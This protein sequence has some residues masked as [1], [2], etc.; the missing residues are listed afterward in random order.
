MKNSQSATIITI[1]ILLLCAK[2]KGQEACIDSSYT[3]SY[4][5]PGYTH[6][7]LDHV[8]TAGD[9]TLMAGNLANRLS[10][11]G[12]LKKMNRAG[13]VLW[14]RSIH[15]AHHTT[16]LTR[17]I[18]M[19]NG[20]ISVL[21]NATDTLLNI[22]KVLL[23]KWTSNGTLLW[24]NFYSLNHE[25]TALDENGR[26][27]YS[28]YLAEG[29]A[30]DLL[31]TFR[32]ATSDLIT[33]QTAIHAVHCR[34]DAS[35]QLKWSKAFSP[36][37]S[38]STDPAG[39]FYNGEDVVAL[40]NVSGVCSGT[41]GTDGNVFYAMKLH[42]ETG[43]QLQAAAYC[44]QPIASNAWEGGTNPEK[45]Y[46]NAIQ[47]QQQQYGLFGKFHPFDQNTYYYSLVLDNELQPLRS[48]L[49]TTPRSLSFGNSKIQLTRSGDIH[50]YALNSSQQ[51]I[52]WSTLGADYSIKRERK[53]PLPRGT[54][55]IN[56]SL[57]FA[58]KGS[59]LNFTGNY[60]TGGQIVNVLTQLQ[61]NDPSLNACLG[62]DTAFVKKQSFPVIAIHWEWESGIDNKVVATPVTAI[63]SRPDEQQE[64][65]CR[66]ISRCE[67]L[68][69]HG[70]DTVC[71]L[72]QEVEFTGLTN[73]GCRKKITWVIDPSVVSAISQPD[74][75]TLRVRFKNDGFGPQTV[76]VIA[77]A[78][79]CSIAKDTLLVTLLPISQ[80]LPA[81]T[82][83][84]GSDSMKLTPGHWF[85]SYVWQDGSTDS[86]LLATK[87]G[88]YYV[89]VQ[90]H[91][92]YVLTDTIRIYGKQLDVGAESIICK[93]DTVSLNTNGGFRDYKWYANGLALQT[94]DSVIQAWPQTNTLFH[95]EAQTHG[96]CVE[97][98]S[99]QVTVLQ[100]K[101][102][103]LGR[104]TTLCEGDSLVLDAGPHFNSYIWGNGDSVQRIV[105]KR[106]GN[107]YVSAL[108]DNGCVSADTMQIRKVYPK[109][110]VHLPQR[111]VL[112]R[113]QNN[114][115]DAGSGFQSY[116]W[117]DGSTR[118]RLTVDVPGTY[119]VRVV[120]RNGCHNTAA[121]LITTIAD[122]PLINGLLDTAMC[123]G[124]TIWLKPG[125]VDASY[126]WNNGS[127]APSLA[128]RSPGVYS[129][130]VTD[131][132]G[133]TAHTAIKVSAKAC[134]S[135]ILFPTAFTPNGDGRNDDF[136]PAIKGHLIAYSFQVFNKWGEK[137]FAT[138]Q[139]DR[140]WDGRLKASR[141]ATDS[142]VWVCQY[143]FAG[144][145]KK[146]VKG[147]IALIQ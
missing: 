121:T 15:I 93:G 102:I 146:V 22:N 128:V 21:G 5:T 99:V 61:Q 108:N 44:Y 3:I 58:E 123:P 62:T 140:G 33:G 96:G 120:D 84:C 76:T 98:D 50:I 11:E 104:D 51:G 95:V 141:Q 47:L 118:Q 45:Q 101:Q 100:S 36:S 83:L 124:E 87:P 106:A 143:Q 103:S 17:V 35:G 139:P 111:N 80:P 29:Q 52:Y 24:S 70:P 26:Q 110:V 72:G 79:D 13:Q 40:G 28:Y 49:L 86:I 68:T 136:K 43:E 116:L 34:T 138:T 23:L 105:V 4:Q 64:D 39:I 38:A 94:K 133:C 97:R 74:D 71:V 16:W 55:N 69:I 9:E 30:H 130:Q 63:V 18:E 144:E 135:S 67:Q 31:F 77:S 54:S 41:P 48:Q 85:K 12:Y 8:N 129:L 46:F 117:Q 59:L 92:G 65:K 122:P 19:S 66:V 112:C 7:I 127:R 142:Y 147:T 2:A 131:N 145:E 10:S 6:T 134:L 125:Q 115:L 109:P 37:N 75:S 53:L 32:A 14:S 81:D 27:V 57:N 25:A 137:V 82:T 60:N 56:S 114:V 1:L 90:A 78:A 126:L 89:T 132:N 119:S 113:D 42:Y 91:C 73:L 20:E 88:T 107:Y